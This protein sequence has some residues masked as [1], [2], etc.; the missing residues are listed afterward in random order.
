M[1]ADAV[2]TFNG[3]AKC[4]EVLVAG[5]SVPQSMPCLQVVS[6]LA[7]QR[8]LPR[9]ACVDWQTIPDVDVAE[10]DLVMSALREAGY[11]QSS[12][13]HVGFLTEPRNDHR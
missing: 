7:Q 2:V 5:D 8:K 4:C 10:F 13:I 1:K 9:G 6:Y 3:P 11:Q 12:G